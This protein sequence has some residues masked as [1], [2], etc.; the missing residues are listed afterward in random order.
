M[1]V[2]LLKKFSKPNSAEAKKNKYE[3]RVSWEGE[4]WCGWCTADYIIQ[5]PNPH[6]PKLSWR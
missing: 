2:I 5:D 6:C 1:I 3:Q 4:A